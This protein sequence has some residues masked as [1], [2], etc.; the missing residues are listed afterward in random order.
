[1]S[2]NKITIVTNN[3]PR[4]L[5]S[6]NDLRKEDQADFDY[7]GEYDKDSPRFFAYKGA[8]YD[9]NEYMRCPDTC[10]AFKDWDGYAGDSYFSGTLIKYVDNY[11][12][13]IVGRYMQ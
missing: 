9:A 5:V 7:I 6:F 1:M 4:T 8:W 12:R 13:V 10:E 3:V 11:E 2:D